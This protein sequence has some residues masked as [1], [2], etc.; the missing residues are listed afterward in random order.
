MGLDGDSV[1]A[2]LFGCG[3]VL[4]LVFLWL[5]GYDRDEG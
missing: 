1:I 2:I 4:W 3:L 5:Q